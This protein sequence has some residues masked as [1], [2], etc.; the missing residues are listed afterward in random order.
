MTETLR[1]K[2]DFTGGLDTEGE[3]GEGRLHGK[4]RAPF[5]F[6]GTKGGS[7]RS[8]SRAAT[9]GGL[10][11][12]FACAGSM[13]LVLWGCSGTTHKGYQHISNGS[14]DFLPVEDVTG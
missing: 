8:T 7:V 10:L 4:G 11:I 5:A 1:D 12:G 3:V 2:S 13:S 6:S 14:H 9:A